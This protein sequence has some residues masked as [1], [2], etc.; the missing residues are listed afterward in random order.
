MPDSSSELNHSRHTRIWVWLFIIV[1]IAAGAYLVFLKKPAP[2]SHSAS[3][4]GSG[5]HASGNPFSPGGGSMAIPVRVAPG[6]QGRIELSLKAVGTVTAFN[7]VTVRSRV[8]GELQKLEFEDGQKV[9]AGQ[10]LAQID[11]RT[12]QASLDQALGQQT[13]DHAQLLNAQRDLQRYQQLYKQN[14]VAKQQLDAQAALVN[15]YWGREKSNQAAVD[16]AKLQLD[17]TRVTAPITG[18][19]GLRRVDQ[20]NLISASDADGLVVITQTQPIS[21]EFTLP[22]GQLPE[23]LAEIRAGKILPVDLYDSNDVAKIATGELSSIDNQIDVAT[24][25]L[26]LKARF[27]NQDEA[28]FPNQFV[29]VRLRVSANDKAI[30]IPTIA[31]QQGSIGAFVY[32]VNQDRK[33]H[34]QPVQTGIVDGDN[35]AVTTGLN[36]GQSVVI[37]GVDRLREGS[38]VEVTKAGTSDPSAPATLTGSSAA[39]SAAP[40]AKAA[41]AAAAPASH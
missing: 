9:Q 29:N 22:Q 8:D 41:P 1:V 13:Q 16:S 5:R 4:Q 31:V 33:V 14:S 15:Q 21:V 36:V 32:T 10:L 39:P 26:K 23:V 2:A 38:E 12:Y 17:F 7:T 18:R 40:A 24:G 27:A 20:G 30:V 6:V 28:L 19:L 34:V 11:P 3:R 35:I 37:E 25:T